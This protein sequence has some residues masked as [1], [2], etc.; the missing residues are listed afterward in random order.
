MIKLTKINLHFG[1]RAIITDGSLSIQ[2]GR[3]CLIHSESG[4][5]K[6]TLLNEIALLNDPMHCLYLMDNQDITTISTKERDELKLR[7]IAYMSQDAKLLDGLCVEDHLKWC[8]QINLIP[9]KQVVKTLKIL[10]LE[11]SKNKKISKL[12]GGERQRV[13][14]ASC[15]LKDADLYIFDEPTSMLDEYHKKI[16]AQIIQQLVVQNK[17]VIV[18]THETEYFHDYDEYTIKD[19]T[20]VVLNEAKREVNGQE[21]SS[22]SKHS[23]KQKLYR[24][25]SVSYLLNFPFKNAI[26]ILL[27]SLCT[28]LMVLLLMAGF[29]NFSEQ[30][31]NI[32]DMYNSEL[33]Y[34]KKDHMEPNYNMDD[35]TNLALDK[36]TI[37]KIKQLENVKS[38]EPYL[39]LN[40]PSRYY[41]L[42]KHGDQINDHEERKVEVIQ[43]NQVIATKYYDDFV[44]DT[45]I[46]FNERTIGIYPTYE[47][48]KYDQ[49]CEMVND[50]DGVYISASLAKYLGIETLA[51]QSIRMKMG[52][53]VAEEPCLGTYAD[54]YQEVG[55]YP[56][57]VVDTMEF[58]IKGIL[59][60]NV[61]GNYGI[62][63]DVDI[64][65]PIEDI[66]AL[67]EKYL[68]KEEVQTLLQQKM[69]EKAPHMQN[70]EGKEYYLITKMGWEASALVIN[71][72]NPEAIY[73]TMAEIENIDPDYVVN[74]TSISTGSIDKN[75]TNQLKKS[76]LLYSC[77]IIV[78]ET[79]GIV[80]INYFQLRSRKNDFTFLYRNGV[81]KSDVQSIEFKEMIYKTGIGVLMSLLI[82]YLCLP[83]VADYIVLPISFTFSTMLMNSLLYSSIVLISYSISQAI[84]FRK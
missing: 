6:T 20:L 58:K 24:S 73:A 84:V 69:Q 3:L 71:V 77:V 39:W 53:V 46:Y 12:S 32:S 56:F 65:M 41:S 10:G 47:H 81:S 40:V 59:K 18:A 29:A 74:L 51:G 15:L 9:L 68:A 2:N 13:A 45:Y 36:S 55:R 79:L 78:G 38:A 64:F 75:I 19:N 34:V 49:R 23:P 4:T 21:V 30:T 28:S 52:V 66:Q 72:D 42:E 54:G 33:F 83:M 57:I 16:V 17:M 43:D 70:F 63:N 11:K 48:Q 27:T 25:L 62:F 22:R 80:V 31:L 50:E 26:F 37:S 44:V 60:E 7:K 61:F 14:F 76:V 35:Y 5:G 1:S 82:T 67:Q 8:A